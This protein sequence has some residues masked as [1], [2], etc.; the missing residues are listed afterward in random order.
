MRLLKMLTL[1]L[2]PCA[3]LAVT[4]V[5]E[6]PVRLTV[7]G[8]V[9]FNPSPSQCRSAGYELI[10]NKPPPTPEE[11][12]AAATA[13]SNAA[14]AFAAYQSSNAVPSAQSVVYDLGRGPVILAADGYGYQPIPDPSTGTWLMQ[15]RTGDATNATAYR[16]DAA[17]TGEVATIISTNRATIDALRACKSTQTNVIDLLT[18]LDNSVWSGAQKT[19]M[20]L[21]RSTLLLQAR[22]IRD[23][24]AALLRAYRSDN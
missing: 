18:T 7:S 6:W 2:V 23:L 11:L 13:A 21:L 24:Q 19:N 17:I 22:E 14:I 4:Y 12:A 8:G 16:S 15:R 20:I 3:V 10:A 9:L 1:M 5:S